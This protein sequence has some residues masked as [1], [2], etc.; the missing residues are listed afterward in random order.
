MKR[1][2]VTILWGTDGFWKWLAAYGLKHFWEYISELIITGRDEEKWKQVANELGAIFFKNNF[3]ALRDADI[4][5]YALPISQ[6]EQ[7]IKETIRYVKSG[8]IVAD[9]TSIKGFPSKAMQV[10]DDITVIP[11]HPMFG[12]YLQSIAWQVIVLTPEVTVKNTLAY[13]FLLDF[14]QKEKAKVVEVSPKEHDRMMAVVQWLTHL[15]MFVIAETM[16]RLDF[17]IE[18]SLNFISPIYKL[19]ISSV[20]RYLGQNPQ[21]YADIQMYNEEV[22]EVHEAFLSTAKNFHISVQ[23]KNTQ[24]FLS[25]VRD[26]RA[27]VW[28]A[29]CSES[30]LYTDK[31]IYM[32]AKQQENLKNN[33]WNTIELRDIYTWAKKVWV[34]EK[35][36]NRNIFFKSGEIYTIDQYEIICY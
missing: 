5:I 21:L 3:E 10:R 19:M 7:I 2:Q 29:F 36:E 28:E 20:G 4:V 11:T 27:Y 23:E 6:T 16:K 15:N 33:I 34:L 9:V 18:K 1:F 24:K 35:Y 30:Q 31:L 32:L 13:K 12:P 26:A 25:D 17:H 14:L 8:A 22:L